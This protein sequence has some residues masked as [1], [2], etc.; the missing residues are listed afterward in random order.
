MRVRDH[1]RIGAASVVRHIIHPLQRLVGHVRKVDEHS[2][3]HEPPD[4]LG[5]PPGQPSLVAVPA[6]VLVVLSL[7]DLVERRR[8]HQRV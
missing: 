4:V 2:A 1:E 7:R 6:G 8:V 5:A 3:F